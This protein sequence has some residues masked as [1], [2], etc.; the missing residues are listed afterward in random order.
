MSSVGRP[1]PW[2]SWRSWQQTY[3]NLISHD[4]EAVQN[5]L[6]KVAA[7][8]CR[9]K[10]PLSVDAFACLVS[11]Q[12]RDPCG[13]FSNHA[14]GEED[15]AVLRMQYAMV[16][17]RL[18][19]GV[20]DSGQK[21]RTANSV[22]T[23]TAAAG[24]P[25]ALVDL[26]HEA[27]H[28]ELPSL[29][30]LRSAAVQAI[31]WLRDTYWERQEVCLQDAMRRCAKLLRVIV[32]YQRLISQGDCAQFPGSA[33]AAQEQLQAKIMEL[34]SLIPSATASLLV[35]AL[36]QPSVLQLP[37]SR[38]SSS[39]DCDNQSKDNSA[40]SSLPNKAAKRIISH[41]ERQSAAGATSQLAVLQQREWQAV[42]QCL[43]REW[44][45]LPGQCLHEA[46]TSLLCGDG[47]A[48]HYYAWVSA[49]HA[50]ASIDHAHDTGKASNTPNQRAPHIFY[51]QPQSSLLAELLRQCLDATSCQSTTDNVHKSRRLLPDLTTL[52]S[53]IAGQNCQTALPDD[54]I[55]DQ[56]K[57]KHRWQVVHDWRPCA[58][59]S[60]PSAHDPNGASYPF[61]MV[62]EAADEEEE[63]L[64][65]KPEAQTSCESMDIVTPIGCDMCPT[66]LA[67][68]Q[69]GDSHIRLPES[70]VVARTHFNLGVVDLW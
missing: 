18:V 63:T 38:D 55:R 47:L 23:I 65:S 26:R 32:N 66:V 50:S 12:L 64:S 8:R 62:A 34:K 11:V 4:A 21:S 45:S 6:Y 40:S 5:G 39:V 52:L 59:G 56:P 28:N 67:K 68:S 43:Q 37:Y 15:D 44:P 27:T 29:P 14:T 49:L 30:V 61:Q 58:I 10:L 69:E 46:V 25:R 24:L 19:N 57:E 36:L 31:S 41:S 33:S 2:C 53:S 48:D 7:W 9:G 42:M 54:T 20:A 51:W 3:R 13:L 16:I 60:V 22:A 70:P 1:V 17:I 35:H